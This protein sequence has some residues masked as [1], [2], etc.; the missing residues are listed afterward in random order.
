MMLGSAAMIGGA[1]AGC[2]RPDESSSTE[3][4]SVRRDVPLRVLL[5]GSEEDASAISRGWGAVTDHPIE[6]ETIDDARD[7]AIALFDKLM[8][9]SVKSDVLIYP[10]AMVA[11]L[12]AN[13]S[14]TA[15]T[16]E[17]LRANQ[18][19]FGDLFAALR[20]GAARYSGKY[21]GLPAGAPLPAL[22]A[23]EEL[24]APNSDETLDWQSY[25]RIV[26]ESWNGS[27]SEPSAPGWAGAMFLWRAASNTSWL[28]HRESFEPLITGEAYV[29]A[30]NQMK[31][32]HARYEAKFQSPDAIWTAVAE[33][34]LRGGIGM[35][36]LRSGA[37]SEPAVIRNMPGVDDITRVLLDPFSPVVSLSVNCRQ[38]SVAKQFIAWI[39]GGEG[40][41]AV[42]SQVTAMTVVR[43]S[44]RRSDPSS[45]TGGTPNYDQWLTSRL[46][47]PVSL[48]TLQVRQGGF[49]YQVLDEQISRVLQGESEPAA[50]L[51][52]VASQWQAK[53]DEIGVD[54]QLRAWRRAQGMRG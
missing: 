15:L 12:D 8:A 31:T 34:K 33:G 9:A 35:P 22:I 43:T 6:I 3:T 20:N 47:S 25:D 51:T 18:D 13:D 28:F 30:L 7:S 14:I 17:E 44:V 52:E 49:Y 48:P 32:T 39:G 37:S 11:Q 26:A 2:D 4:T 16:D 54:K 42:R 46:S 50:A 1:V 38:S 19:E 10:L 40:S 23:G 36:L 27:A 45:G 21:I 24:P 53:T 5:V 41:A 29:D